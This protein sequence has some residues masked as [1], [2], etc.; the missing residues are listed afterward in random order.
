MAAPNRPAPG[1]APAL[2]YIGLGSNLADPGAQIRRAFDALAALPGC[3][4]CARSSLYATRP[5]GPVDQPEFMNAAAALTTTHQPLDLLAALQGIEQAQGRV[6]D[7]TRWGPRTLDLDLLLFD[8]LRLHLPG[9]DLPHP[10]LA[11]RAFVLVPLAEIAPPG[12]LIPGHGALADLI[13]ALGE[14][15]GIRRIRD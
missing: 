12:L 1:L 11:R 7:G 8:A 15:D 3:T 4:L 5:I 10:E 9:L 13:A 2:A 6:R 14:P